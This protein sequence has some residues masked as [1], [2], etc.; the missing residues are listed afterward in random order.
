MKNPIPHSWKKLLPTALF[1]A[2]CVPGW[3][4][5][6]TR[7]VDYKDD[8]GQALE[9]YVVFDDAAR[10]R[11]PAVIVVHDWRGL[12]DFTHR[13]AEMLAGLG[14]VAFA[15]DI[16][17]KDV[18]LTTI[19]QWQK[20]IV[21]YKDDRALFRTR[22]RAAYEACI[23]LPEVDP[24]RVAAIGYCFGG[25]GVVEMLR[26]GLDLRGIVTFHGG[27]DA[28]P[29]S[30]GAAMRA[31]VLA[32]CGA[33]DPYQSEADLAAFEK[34]LKDGGVDY[35]IVKYG[36]AVH[37]FTDAEVDKLNLPGAKYNAAADRRSW[38]AMCDFLE[39]IFAQ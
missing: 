32:L 6:V 35:E 10:E 30:E 24:R 37:A 28:R 15:A 12:T 4:K 27:L 17:G 11:R 20:E 8:S 9:G 13:R 34:Q 33:D 7:T 19:P 1:L 5:I 22:E 39:E 29:L 26:D 38:R 2:A 21:K 14:Y 18:H 25:T 3:A 23:K 31:K 16:Y 36:H